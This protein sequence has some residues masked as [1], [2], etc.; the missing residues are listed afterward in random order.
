[1]QL[2]PIYSIGSCDAFEE[3]SMWLFHCRCVAFGRAINMQSLGRAL[4]LE[5]TSKYFY[6]WRKQGSNKSVH[7][8]HHHARPISALFIALFNRINYFK[9][10][11]KIFSI[12]KHNEIIIFFIFFNTVL[13]LFLECD[14]TFPSSKYYYSAVE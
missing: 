1:M 7:H 6:L 14:A 12:S 3:S 2:S 10:M 13:L 4:L 9:K 5:N 11:L 8:Y